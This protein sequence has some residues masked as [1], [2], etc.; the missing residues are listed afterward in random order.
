MSKKF[1]QTFSSLL[2]YLLICSFA[3]IVAAQK[4]K[5][6]VERND[7]KNLA[8]SAEE[9]AAMRLP[10]P[11]TFGTRSKAAM[12]PIK[13]GENLQEIEIPVDSPDNFKLMLLTP[14]GKNLNLKVALPNEDFFDLRGDGFARRIEETETTYGLD[15]NQFPSE[16]FTFASIRQG[17]LRV[18]IEQ[19]KDTISSGE[20]IGYLVASSESPFR[21]YSFINTYQTTIGREVGIIASLFDRKSNVEEGQPNSLI[22]NIRDSRVLL[23]TPKGENIELSMTE[24]ENGEF[25]AN[26]VPQ[27][28]GRYKVQIISKGFTPDGEEF[29]RTAEHIFEVEATRAEFYS[30]AKASLIDDFRWRIDLPVMGLKTGKKVIAHAEV[31]GRGA[32]GS[33]FPVAWF[34]GIALTEKS[35]KREVSVPL[36]LDSRWLAQNNSAKSFVLKNVRLQNPDNSVVWGEAETIS[37]ANIFASDFAKSFGGTIN[38]EMR[39]GVR[40]VKYSNDA[41]GGKLMLVHGYC[42]SDVWSAAASA[43]QF[44]NYVKFLDLNQNRSHDQFANLIKNF[45]AGLP[46]YGIVAHSQG[47]AA[48][49]HL[50]TYYWSGLDSATGTRLIQSVGTPYQGTALAGNLAILGQIF[51][52]GC[53]SNNDMTYSGAAAWL[54]N[55]PSWARAKVYFHTTSFTDVWWR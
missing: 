30:D 34:G 36:I 11:A 49:L 26:F 15:G 22:G 43:G 9:V 24:R 27:T 21:L 29:L 5:M 2:L 50:Y 17:I 3:L 53:G 48:S 52:A 16:V 35:G 51:G 46:S 4:T 20:T 19:P 37:V 41:A 12:I 7:F 40:P 44:S 14:N 54:A 38:D 42:S 28:A 39:Q 45:G 32:D 33:E 6:T 18:Q 8:G 10:N 55:I 23:Q 25:Q 31:W 13:S 1:K 47:G